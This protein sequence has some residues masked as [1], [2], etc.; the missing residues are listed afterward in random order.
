MSDANI[1]FQAAADG[2]SATVSMSGN[3]TIESITELHRALREGLDSYQRLT[4][5]VHQ[6]SSIDLPAMQ[7]LCSACRTAAARQRI[8]L[9]GTDLPECMMSTGR[10]LGASPGLPCNQNSNDPCIWFGGVK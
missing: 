9:S 3:M 5:D 6:L 7:L 4:L 8:M 10:N 2:L 1:T